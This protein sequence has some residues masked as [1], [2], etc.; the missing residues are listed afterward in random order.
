M[1]P[2]WKAIL[3]FAGVFVA[4]GLCG[5]ALSYR[6]PHAPH[7]RPHIMQRLERDLALTDAQKEKIE[8]MVHRAQE[9]VQRLRRENI[10]SIGA[11]MEKLQSDIAAELTPEQRVK[12][13]AMRKRFRE[14][15]ERMRAEFRDRSGPPSG[16]RS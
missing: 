12:Q 15:V 16:D 3:A 6:L 8:P 9:D 7:P 13:D 11:V 4:G 5:V 2:S 1:D 10:R 14:R